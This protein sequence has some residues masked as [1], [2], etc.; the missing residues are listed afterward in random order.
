MNTNTREMAL[1]LLFAL[2][3]PL[4]ALIFANIYIPNTLGID[5]FSGWRI[6]SAI[7]SFSGIL[8][9]GAADGIYK[10][11]LVNKSN[12]KIQFGNF[13]FVVILI[14]VLSAVVVI[15]SYYL[16]HVEVGSLFAL[17]FALI[18]SCVMSFAVYYMQIHFN[19]WR[20]KFSIVSQ[21]VAFIA[22]VFIL[23][24]LTRVN[25]SGMIL[26]YGLSCLPVVIISIREGI[27]SPKYDRFLF[28]SWIKLGFPLLV[29]NLGI[30]L[31]IN[32]DKIF[33]R[34]FFGQHD[35]FAAYSI[36]SSLFVAA[37]SL[38]LSIGGILVSRKVEI[39]T[40]YR[41]LST[42]VFSL[43]TFLFAAPLSSVM[44]MLI[45]SYKIDY[46]LAII[47]GSIAFCVSIFYFSPSRVYDSVFMRNLLLG[48]VPI[49]FFFVTI[50]LKITSDFSK[51][52]LISLGVFCV[53]FVVACELRDSKLIPSVNVRMHRRP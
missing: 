44:N 16:F 12:E 4:T 53:F 6:A 48:F 7:I 21:S 18:C 30:I 1:N 2:V 25:A 5:D 34:Y 46:R 20:L 27:F 29:S 28:I 41:V 10:T 49:Y 50:L 38:G 14:S 33:A 8:H 23:N 11:W 13:L 52:S 26:T 32:L 43:M 45:K 31:F 39:N 40:N 24:R 3:I 51:S 47:L 15:S 9:L 19:D 37:V 42:V 22:A 36:E 35:A 17:F